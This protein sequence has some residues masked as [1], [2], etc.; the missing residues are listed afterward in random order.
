MGHTLYAAH[1]VLIQVSGP[2]SAVEPLRLQCQVPKIVAFEQC[3]P[4][5]QA[6]FLCPLGQPFLVGNQVH[7]SFQYELLVLWHM[8]QDSVSPSNVV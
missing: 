3:E 1:E 4:A 7:C 2:C 5:L 6:L 8:E